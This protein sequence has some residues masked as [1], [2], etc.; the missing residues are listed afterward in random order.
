MSH[1]EQS[2]S[3]SPRARVCVDIALRWG[4]QDEYGHINNVAY[5]RY[6]E[7]AR[8]RVFSLGL[9]DEYAGLETIFAGSGEIAHKMLLASQHIEFLGVL[10]YGEAPARIEMWIGKIGGSS[11]D[12]HAEIFDQGSAQAL[13]A[14]AV[15]T[16]VVVDGDTLRPK[17]LA[18]TEREVLVR[19]HAEPLKMRRHG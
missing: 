5:P 7:E 19:W 10:P 8:V 16:L 15:S 3:P 2:G 11:F 12:V 14:R 4:D 13:V 1:V 9:G 6:L 17:R 18:A